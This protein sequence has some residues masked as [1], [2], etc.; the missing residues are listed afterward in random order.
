MKRFILIS[1]LATTVVAQAQTPSAQKADESSFKVEVSAEFA[2]ALREAIARPDAP[3]EPKKTSFSE[4]LMAKLTYGE[5]EYLADDE[6][7]QLI[8]LAY[9]K[10]YARECSNFVRKPQTLRQKGSA[11]FVI[12]QKYV[13]RFEQYASK[14]P[15]LLDAVLH[16]S[17][18][19][20]YHTFLSHL[21]DHFKPGCQSD[22]VARAYENLFR[23]SYNH[24]ALSLLDTIYLMGGPIESPDGLYLVNK[25]YINLLKA[26]FKND[27]GSY[28]FEGRT[29]RESPLSSG[30]GTSAARDLMLSGRWYPDTQQIYGRELRDSAICGDWTEPFW[31]SSLKPASLGLNS[32]PVWA[33]SEIYPA[34][35]PW[36]SICEVRTISVSNCSFVRCKK[37]SRKSPDKQKSYLVEGA[38]NAKWVYEIHF[39]GK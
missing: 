37:W 36:R 31:S 3:T 22:I 26:G 8:Y 39:Y 13:T 1:F 20:K 23:R 28:N 2:H 16:S 11:E 7:F 30:Y 6:L 24:I 9:V 18:L 14:A 33:A 4:S 15:A 32:I 21:N 27:D 38:A 5:F 10:R 29:I 35:R 34:H 19:H 25:Y 17:Q 12:E